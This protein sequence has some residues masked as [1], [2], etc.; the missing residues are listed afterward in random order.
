MRDLII[1]VL[2]V[3]T[4][5]LAAPV[6]DASSDSDKLHMNPNLQKREPAASPVAPFHKAASPPTVGASAP[7]L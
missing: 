4:C 6:H 1:I 7:A 2:A 5:A 3:S